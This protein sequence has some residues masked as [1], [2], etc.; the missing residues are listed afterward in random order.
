MNSGPLRIGV[1]G[2]ADIAW[3]RAL[4][5]LAAHPDVRLTAIASRDPAKARRFAGRF[6][7]EPVTGYEALLERP[8]VDAVYLPLPVHLHAEWIG[9]ALRSGRH[10][11]A[12]KPLTASAEETEALVALAESRGLALLENFMFLCHSQHAEVRALLARGAI[13]ELRT[14]T[15]EFAFPPM[16]DGRNIYRSDLGGGVLTEV[17]VYPLRTALLYLGADLEIRGVYAH[18]DEARGVDVSG[19]ALLVAPGGVTAH[20]TWGAERAYRSRYALWGSTGRIELTWA[21][22]PSAAHRAV[23][24]IEHQDR[25]EELTLPAEDHFASAAAAFVARVRD[26]VPS[27]LEGRSLVDQARLVDRVRRRALDPAGPDGPV[28]PA[29]STSGGSRGTR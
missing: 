18:V 28:T 9:R 21:Y 5:A 19:G 25:V 24:R 16:A 29:A 22:T 12:E 13:G 20:L 2:C 26:G 8:D 7:A 3:R 27:V 6:G 1:I 4:P 15:A 11:L 10:V 17:G 23:I 14:L